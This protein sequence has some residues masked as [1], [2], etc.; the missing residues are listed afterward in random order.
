MPLAESLADFWSPGLS[1]A[2][3]RVLPPSPVAPPDLLLRLSE[4]PAVSVRGQPVLD[5][6]A[7]AYA[8]LA[9]PEAAAD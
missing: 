3:L 4:P 9:D 1:Q 7:P 8:R 5:L 2:R 6:I